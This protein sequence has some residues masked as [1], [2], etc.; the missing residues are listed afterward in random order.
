MGSGDQTSKKHP[1]R[2]IVQHTVTP[3]QLSASIP[4]PLNRVR[5]HSVS[6]SYTRQGNAGTQYCHYCDKKLTSK[7]SLILHIRTAHKPNVDD[8]SVIQSFDN[9]EGKQKFKLSTS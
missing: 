1:P 5:S 8:V 2:M 9:S 7:S 3:P 4:D 6:T